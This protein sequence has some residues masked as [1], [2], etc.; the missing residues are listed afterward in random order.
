MFH[1][2]NKLF[3]RMPLNLD[4]FDIFSYLDSGCIFGRISKTWCYVITSESINCQTCVQIVTVLMMLILIIQ[5]DA[6]QVSPPSNYSFPTV[7]NQ[8]CVWVRGY[9]ENMHCRSDNNSVTTLSLGT[10]I[11]VLYLIYKNI[12]VLRKYMLNSEK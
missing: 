6:C 12:F 4:Q 2:Y 9:Y 3:S 5:C 7:I 11:I 10:L 8:Q 1:R